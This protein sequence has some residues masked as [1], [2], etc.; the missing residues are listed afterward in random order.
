MIQQGTYIAEC[1]RGELVPCSDAAG[2]VEDIGD[3]VKVFKK[4]VDQSPPVN[5]QGDRVC[6]ILNQGHL[7]GDMT[8]EARETGLGGQIDGVLQHYRVVPGSALSNPL[9]GLMGLEMSLV[10]IPDF[11]S[12]EEASTLPCAGVTVQIATTTN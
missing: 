1:K 3:Q 11:L 8:P 5:V 6:P 2:E 9:M 4:V 10:K 7:Y 12:Y